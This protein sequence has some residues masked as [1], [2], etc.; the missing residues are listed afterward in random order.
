MV[1]SEVAKDVNLIAKCGLYCAACGKYQKGKCPG[2]TKNESAS[3]CKVRSCCI[4]NGYRSCADCKEFENAMDCKKF[5]NAISK[6]FGFVFRSDRNACIKLIKEKGY[7][8]F[9]LH[10]SGNKLQSIRRSYT[11]S[12]NQ[13][14]IIR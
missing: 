4:A 8:N 1:N 7:E 3:W 14:V 6:I 11:F 12:I 13:Y 2:C 5:N 10:M 9:A